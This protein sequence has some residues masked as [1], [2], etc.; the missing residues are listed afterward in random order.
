MIRNA[1]SDLNL[2]ERN[3][4][5]YVNTLKYALIRKVCHMH[6]QDECCAG[7]EEGR[8]CLVEISIDIKYDGGEWGG[9][10]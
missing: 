2:W 4:K 3:D 5:M 1:N 7:R 10:P 9:G 8:G 6:C